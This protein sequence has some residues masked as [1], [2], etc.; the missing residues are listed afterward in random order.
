MDGFIAFCNAND[1]VVNVKKTKV[2][3]VHLNAVVLC[4]GEPLE[5]VSQFKYLGLVIDAQSTSPVCILQ[6]RVVKAK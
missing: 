2:M 5:C 1:L 3:C 6:Q 4:Q